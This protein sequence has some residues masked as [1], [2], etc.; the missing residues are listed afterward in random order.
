MQNETTALEVRPVRRAELV[1]TSEQRKM[2][3]D[4]YAPGA[5]D[6]EF[7]VLMEIAKAKRLNPLTGQIHFVRRW[8]QEGD[9]WSCQTGIDGFRAIAADTGLYDGQDEPEF[10]YHETLDQRTGAVIGK[11]P[12]TARVR[13]Y[14]KDVSRPFVGVAH[15]EEYVQRKKDGSPNKMWAE[16]PHIMLGKV[17]EA[18][19]LRRAFPEDLGG[20][21]APD[22]M[23]EAA[24][25]SDAVRMSAA[26]VLPPKPVD[27]VESFLAKIAEAS[28]QEKLDAVAA[29]IGKV[30][31]SKP[32]RAV[33]AGAF[34]SR[35]EELRAGV[36]GAIACD[37]CGLVGRHADGCPQ[38]PE[39]EPGA[40]G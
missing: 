18:L 33:L 19:A 22:E 16:K 29:Q 17:A 25:P 34:K 32:Q 31:W 36:D 13:V 24:A 40:E 1:F 11:R 9:R 27:T 6:S 15:Y 37:A 21:N 28:S 10:T 7:A 38:L 3:R 12:E 39:R 14:R 20:L 5:T 8:T 26:P 30:K 23:G 35:G 4:T 2:I